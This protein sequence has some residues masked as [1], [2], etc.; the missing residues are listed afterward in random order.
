M[1][2]TIDR[3]GRIV[4]P[5]PLRDRLGLIAGT[6]IEIEE[7]GG[8]VEIRPRGRDVHVVEGAGGFL[9]LSAADCHAVLTDADV[10]EAI[11]ETRRWPRS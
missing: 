1:K 7:R 5:K 3:A 11:E 9:V 2:S 4:V 8:A 6:E 10:R